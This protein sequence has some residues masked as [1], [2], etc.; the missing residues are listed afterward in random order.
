[1]ARLTREPHNP[2][3]PLAVAV[4]LDGGEQRPWRIGYL[5]RGVAARVA[6]RMDAGLTLDARVDGWIAEPDGRWRRPVVL[7][8]PEVIE[9]AAPVPPAEPVPAAER[10]E[11]PRP[12]VWGRPPGV[13]RRIVGQASSAGGG[14][15]SGAGRGRV[16]RSM[17]RVW[18]T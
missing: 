3:D 1:M 18:G 12:G 7:L 9:P 8:L 17:M 5:D 4:W 16:P 14:D 10:P 13:T 11:P 6:P 2:A 15:G